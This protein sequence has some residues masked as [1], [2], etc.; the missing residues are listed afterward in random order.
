[1]KEPSKPVLN[2]SSLAHQVV[3]VVEQQLDFAARAFQLGDW[4]LALAEGSTRH[5][6]GI[7][8]V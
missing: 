8:G 3:A 5:R 4:E 2:S 7:N 1:V 6:Q